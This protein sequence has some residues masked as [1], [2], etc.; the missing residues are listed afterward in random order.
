MNEQG[1]ASANQLLDMFSWKI[2]ER[3][4]SLKPL[5]PLVQQYLP[6]NGKTPVN[7]PTTQCVPEDQ[8]NIMFVRGNWRAQSPIGTTGR[9]C[10][11]LATTGSCVRSATYPRRHFPS[12]IKDDREEPWQPVMLASDQ[13]GGW[14]KL[15]CV[16]SCIY[17]TN[18][19]DIMPTWDRERLQLS[20]PLLG[21]F[22]ITGNTHLSIS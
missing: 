21:Y 15:R 17:F 19:A 2:A 13:T 3:R 11:L 6:S 8:Q 9:V 16:F 1:L 7:M 20:H 4:L 10:N 22:N 18:R 5:I 14:W 12:D